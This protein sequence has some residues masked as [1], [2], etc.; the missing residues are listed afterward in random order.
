MHDLR[1]SRPTWNDDNFG[2]PETA[3]DPGP[4][5]PA[6]QARRT[7]GNG[8]KR[9]GRPPGVITQGP[10]ASVQRRAGGSAARFSA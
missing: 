8:L 4:S 10:A 5:A 6:K 9:S 1:R 2:A 7:P 3:Y